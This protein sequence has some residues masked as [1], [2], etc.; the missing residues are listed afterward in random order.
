MLNRYFRLS[1]LLLFL[2]FSVASLHAEPISPRQIEQFS[3]M[4][5]SCIGKEYPNK[6][7]LAMKSDQDLAPPHEL[8]PIFYG[9][10]DWHSSVH[11][12]WLLVRLMRLYPQASFV[13]DAKKMLNRSFTD[14][15]VK[16][17]MLFAEKEYRKSFERPYG[18]AWFLQ[19]LAE[20]KEWDSPD[21]MGWAKTLQPMETLF[22]SRIQNWVP[23]LHYPIRGGT[24]GQTAFAFGLILDWARQTDNSEMEAVIVDAVNRFY[25]KDELCP[26]AYEP[27]GHDFLSPCL[28]E[29]D[30]VR[31]VLSANAYSEWLTRFLPN[32]PLENTAT[33][34]AV[35][36]VNDPTDGHLVHL[37]G[38]NLS[39]AWALEGIAEALPMTD[40]RKFSLLAA[41]ATHKS[42]G[43][44]AVS[45][46][47]YMGS[48]WLASFATY[49]VTQR[50]L[51]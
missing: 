42:S 27:S 5:L 38:V 37:D 22:A 9:C 1:T 16:A 26:I 41:A 19:L 29:A 3:T 34:L 14:A 2:H 10:Y 11:G 40:K 7:G 45:S 28:M 24:H 33:W 30:L 50:G 4:A 15:N 6:I 48:H 36:V 46:E 23:K 39:R 43:L 18:I 25:I 12:H 47:H 13:E 44:K 35:G 51:K 32:I 49:L 8:T 20:L 17:E 31:R 21:S